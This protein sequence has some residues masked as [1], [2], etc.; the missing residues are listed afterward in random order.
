MPVSNLPDDGVIFLSINTIKNLG[1]RD[2][3]EHNAEFS[4]EIKVGNK[5]I[6]TF[7]NLVPTDGTF[8]ISESI[9]I[10]LQ[11]E[12]RQYQSL[13]FSLKC[14]YERDTGTQEVEIVEK[15]PVKQR[16]PFGKKKYTYKST[17]VTQPKPSDPW[18]KIIKLDGSYG[19]AV[20]PL[21]RAALSEAE[22]KSMST[23][24]NLN[25]AWSKDRGV[26]SVGVIG[27]SLLWIPRNAAEETIPTTLRD[28][29]RVAEKYKYQKA[30]T[31]E[32]YLM[33]E[34]ADHPGEPCRR[35]FMLNGTQLIGCH[36]VTLVPEIDINLLQAENVIYGGSV[37]GES[38][39]RNFTN[40]TNLILLGSNIKLVFRDGEIINLYVESEEVE[41]NDWFL[42]LREVVHLNA[43][44]QPWVKKYVAESTG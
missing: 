42:K 41:K 38:G 21:D 3:K 14:H 12:F 40:F 30:I 5:V 2:V 31:K 25:N 18:D 33:Q 11:P 24:L 26:H 44:H 10:E 1:L 17:F 7:N 9:H 4:L 29:E 15:V 36:E 27:V 43:Y 32:G 37:S 16:F 35:Y 39:K 23:V 28:V 8:N 34:G 6:K 20:L 19:E 22:N 13:S